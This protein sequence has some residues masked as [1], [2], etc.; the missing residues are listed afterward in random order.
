[1]PFISPEPYTIFLDESGDHNLQVIDPQYP[2]FGLC[3]VLMASGDHDPAAARLAAWKTGFFGRNVVLHTREITRNLGDFAVLQNRADRTRFW[4]QLRPQIDAL[5]FQIV[6]GVI[7]KQRHYGQ[8]GWIAQDP[9]HLT[10]EFLVERFYMEMRSRGS[11]AGLV[12][13][14]RN[15]RLDA[16]LQAHYAALMQ[17]GTRFVLAADLQRYLNPT[18][19][20]QA[21]HPDAI[22]L[23]IADLMIGPVCRDAVGLRNPLCVNYQHRYRTSA[24]GRI[25]GYGLK[26]FP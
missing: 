10:L 21:K 26:V 19:D 25:Q 7:D 6:A 14:G 20:V 9:Y 23:Q 3:G 17:N 15:P 22:G 1:M 4:T 12:A 13:E 16:A 18:L 5:R 24:A 8:Y 2:V 11:R